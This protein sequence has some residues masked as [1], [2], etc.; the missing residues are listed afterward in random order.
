MYSVPLSLML[1][2]LPQD[3]NLFFSC[4]STIPASTWSMLEATPVHHH[5]LPLGPGNCCFCLSG[6][7]GTRVKTM[8][9][10]PIELNLEGPGG[11]ATASGSSR[12]PCKPRKGQRQLREELD[13]SIATA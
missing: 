4:S 7:Q 10:E 9:W 8:L 13:S 3:S 5:L 11:W 2:P 6:T 1:D 12:V